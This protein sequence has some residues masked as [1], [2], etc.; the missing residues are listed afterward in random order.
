MKQI[1]ATITT[2]YEARILT[3]ETDKKHLSDQNLQLRSTVVQFTYTIKKLGAALFVAQNMLKAAIDP[4]LPMDR[5][6]E[7]DPN[8]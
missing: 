5:V 8:A 1:K 4:Q 2:A 3:L 7:R 6:V